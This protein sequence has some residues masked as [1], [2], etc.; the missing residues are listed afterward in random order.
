MLQ[1]LVYLDRRFVAGRLS[2]RE[3]LGSA[4]GLGFSATL[5]PCWLEA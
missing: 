1:E 5:A 4:T 3:F 2:R